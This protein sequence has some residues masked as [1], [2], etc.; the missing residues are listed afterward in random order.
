MQDV[1]PIKQ[2]RTE[3]QCE[4]RGVRSGHDN[5]LVVFR[6]ILIR[7]NAARAREVLQARHF[8]QKEIPA[9]RIGLDDVL[10]ILDV[11]IFFAV[12]PA[13]FLRLQFTY[14]LHHERRLASAPKAV[15]RAKTRI[16]F[17]M[18][19]I[20]Q[21]RE[22]KAFPK[23]GKPLVRIDSFEIFSR[24]VLHGLLLFAISCS[25]SPHIFYIIRM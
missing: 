2:L 19:V 7:E 6:H 25:F 5:L 16:P 4:S 18:Q 14:C 13:D 3:C 9:L 11:I 12:H 1:R 8:I 21:L 20:H 22:Y 24:R 23:R 10:H 17:A 15:K